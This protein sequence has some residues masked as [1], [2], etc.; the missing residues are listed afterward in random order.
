[1]SKVCAVSFDEDEDE[2]VEEKD[3]EE[4]KKSDENVVVHA[5]F[6]IEH[7]FITSEYFAGSKLGY[8]FKNGDQGIGYYKDCPK[9]KIETG[10]GQSKNLDI[11]SKHQRDK[12]SI[13]EIIEAEPQVMKKQK[14]VTEEA[15]CETVIEKSGIVQAI[16]PEATL[17][18]LYG[19][20]VNDK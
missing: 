10:E 13:E 8:V 19:Y 2:D 1:M 9:Q 17:D 20:L 15:E 7:V 6:K 12:P 11:S 4:A 3:Q 16:S 5:D 14:S 18:K